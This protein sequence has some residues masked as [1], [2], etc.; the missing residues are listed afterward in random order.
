[1]FCLSRAC[2]CAGRSAGPYL[3]AYAVV[4]GVLFCASLGAYVWSFRV[5]ALY[6]DKPV[7]CAPHRTASLPLSA[8]PSSDVDCAACAAACAVRGASAHVAARQ[9]G[10]CTRYL[11]TDCTPPPP[12]AALNAFAGFEF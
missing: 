9:W 11:G 10:C 1:M 4:F 2:L 3:I 7:R 6:H 8:D 12:F 5:Y